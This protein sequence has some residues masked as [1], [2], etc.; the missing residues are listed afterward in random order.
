MERPKRLGTGEELK[1]SHVLQKSL[2]PPVLVLSAVTP[3]AQR[4]ALLCGG[5]SKS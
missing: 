3:P 5:G 2:P 1:R 4:G